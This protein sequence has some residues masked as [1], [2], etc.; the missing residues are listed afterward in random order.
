[1]GYM[2][3]AASGLSGFTTSVV[4]S[5]E[6]ATKFVFSPLTK[7]Q[8]KPATAWQTV[9]LNIHDSTTVSVSSGVSDVLH[10]GQYVRGLVMWVGFIIIGLIM[11]AIGLKTV[12]DGR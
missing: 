4:T 2:G 10:P 1:M 9:L 8:P 7:G 12:L 3:A 6:N 11:I 5:V